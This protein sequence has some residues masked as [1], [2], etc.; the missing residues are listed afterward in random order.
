MNRDIQYFLADSIQTLW[1]GFSFH[2]FEGYKNLMADTDFSYKH[3]AC[4][5][6]GGV[7]YIED[8]QKKD[9]CHLCQRLYELNQIQ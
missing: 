3:R 1:P 7:F 6:C 9:I 5:H 8:E 4:S 2:A